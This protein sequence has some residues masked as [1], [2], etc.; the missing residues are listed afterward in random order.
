MATYAKRIGFL[1]K[2]R[3]SRSSSFMR[4]GSA[5]TLSY[6]RSCRGC[7]DMPQTSLT[8]ESIQTPLGM[9]FRSFGS[10]PLKLTMPPSQAPKARCF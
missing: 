1:R 10:T 7:G 4:T 8:G 5:L 6:A 9:D 3:A 2:K